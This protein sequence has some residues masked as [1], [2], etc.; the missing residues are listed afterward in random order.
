MRSS[1]MEKMFPFMLICQLSLLVMLIV[2]PELSSAQPLR[3]GFY[4][5]SCP[6][7]ERIVREAVNKAVANN[8]GIAAGL[9]RLSFH[10]CFVRGCDASIL[11]KSVPGKQSEQDHVANDGTL[12][13]V[14][15]IDEAKTKLEAACPRTVSCADILAFAARDGTNSVGGISYA[16][17]AGRRDGRISSIS[18]VTG[19]L[20][21]PVASVQTLKS[22]FTKKGMSLTQMVALSGA[23]SIGVAHCRNFEGRLY[24]FNNTHPQDPSL[25]AKYASFLKTR[26]PKRSDG[27][28]IASLDFTT[29]N[30][31]DVEYYRNL[32]KK[33]GVLSS[34]QALESSPLT[35]NTVRKYMN[36]STLWAADFAAAM[37]H[38]S[39]IDV[40]T[41]TAGEIRKK[42]EVVN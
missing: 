13:G 33:M 7:A 8:P 27:N 26:C 14:E 36:N 2:T 30:R 29:P 18:E 37:V 42:C 32:K 22:F 1:C 28:N 17:P 24:S 23:H 39:T 4:R 20:P 19:N 9:I 5:K 40:L 3:V 10:D 12:R 41:G 34:D 31:L 35:A 15:V 16:V 38:L 6:S 25:D 21:P 11:L